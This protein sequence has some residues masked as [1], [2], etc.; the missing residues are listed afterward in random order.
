MGWVTNLF[1]SNSAELI[2]AEGNVL[3]NLFTSDEELVTLDII[4]QRLARQP[5]LAQSEVMKVQARFK[6]G[7]VA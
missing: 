5:A 4:K 7:Y 3:D 2:N 6:S 1:T